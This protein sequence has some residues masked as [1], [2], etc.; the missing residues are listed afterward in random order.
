MKIK[1]KQKRMMYFGLNQH[2]K[3]TET[4]DL[5]DFRS[6]SSSAEVIKLGFFLTFYQRHPSTRQQY[7]VLHKYLKCPQWHSQSVKALSHRRYRSFVDSFLSFV[8]VLV[9]KSR[10][11]FSFLFFIYGLN[12]PE[13][14]IAFD[15][16]AFQSGCNE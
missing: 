13:L 5:C 8:F 16:C 11:R 15:T 7:M 9:R 6:C 2:S 10:L 4:F 14:N 12:V 1:P 3:L